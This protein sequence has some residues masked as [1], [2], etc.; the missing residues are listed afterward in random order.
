ML[1]DLPDEIIDLILSYAPDFRDN[2]KNCQMEILD[3]HRPIYLKKVI[4]GFTPGIAD[5]PT[6][7]NFSDRNNVI[8][9]WRQGARVPMTYIELKLHAIE[10][11]PEREVYGGEE[12]AGRWWHT[13]NMYLYYGWTKADNKIYFDTIYEWN[14]ESINYEFTPGYY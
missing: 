2:L 6:W 9:V 13:R 4:A 5:S 12:E 10:I 1:P 7:H 8:R 11:T 3:N 14:I